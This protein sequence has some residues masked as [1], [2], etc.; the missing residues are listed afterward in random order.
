MKLFLFT[1]LLKCCHSVLLLWICFS[2][3]W[4]IW[5][6]SDLRLA[7]FGSVTNSLG[8]VTDSEEALSTL[9]P[10]LSSI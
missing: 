3:L 4:F 10:R 2:L 5:V 8:S 7:V 1:F 6:P 9:L